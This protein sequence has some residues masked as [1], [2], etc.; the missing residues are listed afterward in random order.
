MGHGD[1][2]VIGDLNFPAASNARNLVRLDG[3]GV[4]PVLKAILGL[5][6][7]DD[8]VE[9]PVTLMQV[10]AG[11]PTVPKI[12]DSI[13]SLVSAWDNRPTAVGLV[14]RFQFYERARRAYAI[15]STGETQLYACAILKKGVFA[16]PVT[17]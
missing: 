6:P 1:D 11:D 10:V 16:P 8:F 4:E 15:V 5:F 2:L 3:F 12:Q 13:R 17:N 7:L 14:D 9:S